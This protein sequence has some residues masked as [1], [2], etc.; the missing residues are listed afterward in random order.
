MTYVIQLIGVFSAI[1][2]FGTFYLSYVQS[3]ARL[4][5]L[6]ETTTKQVT[7]CKAV[8]ELKLM[9]TTDEKKQDAA[10]LEA[11]AEVEYI[12]RH[13]NQEL[14]Y[15]TWPQRTNESLVKGGKLFA[16][17]PPK[18][19]TGVQKLQWVAYKM[20]S[21]FFVIVYASVATILIYSYSRKVPD[22][23][24]VPGYVL[25][26]AEL[27]VSLFMAR[28]YNMAANK[29]PLRSRPRAPVLGHL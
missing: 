2:A 29:L 5:G 8:L 22:L 15:M 23:K 11:Y 13:A 17:L 20:V 4:S 7:L 16:I 21:W 28:Y 24:N 6:I 9:A 26:V 3:S 14:A 10:R 18:S 12:F 19:L 27:L 25:G 1:A